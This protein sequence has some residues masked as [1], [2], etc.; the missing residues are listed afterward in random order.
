MRRDEIAAL[1][2]SA[3]VPAVSVLLPIEQPVT[4]HPETELRL[5]ALVDEAIQ[6]AST[7]WDAAAADAV[8]AQIDAA[9]VRIEAGEAALGLAL[10]ASPDE[11]RVLRLPFRVEE[12]VI[13]D[14]TYATRQLLEGWARRV[15]HRVVVLDRSGARLLEGEDEHLAEVRAHGFPVH[16]DRPTEQDTP[17]RDRPRHEMVPEEDGRAVA[18]AVAAALTLAR[19]SDPRPVVLVGEE[20]RVATLQH[21]A[22]LGDDLV[23][24]VHGDHSRDRDQQIGPLVWPTIARWSSDRAARS[25][26]RLRDAAGQGTAV[27]TFPAVLAAVSE[28]RGREL[29]VEEGF[30]MPRTWLDGLS[31]GEEPDPRIETEDMVDDVI[32]Q[33]LSKGGEVTFVAP[34]SLDDC[35][36]IGLLLRW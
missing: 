15:K 35:G 22:D 2:G 21:V 24:V 16:L 27:T 25:C 10:F 3:G 11:H 31:P 17:H 29:I 20:R 5:R 23:G 36:R 12:E 4:A 34:G 32:E 1:A 19:R 28:G 7:W 18:R 6:A 13:V 8:R 26:E 33:V 30:A 14:T 9:G